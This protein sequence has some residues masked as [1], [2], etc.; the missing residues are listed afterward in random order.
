MKNV[1]AMLF[2]MVVLLSGCTTEQ[3]YSSVQDSARDSC[4]RMME[5]DRSNCLRNNQTD[6][7]TYKNSTQR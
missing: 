6:Y 2:G 7:Q 4:N 3:L 1:S 5:P